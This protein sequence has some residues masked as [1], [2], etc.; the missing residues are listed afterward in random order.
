MRRVIRFQVAAVNTNRGLI[1]RY[2]SYLRPSCA[3][4]NHEKRLLYIIVFPA[5]LLA[6]VISCL[7]YPLNRELLVRFVF[8]WHI[9]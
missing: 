7:S 8:W 4:Q 1:C 9:A 5:R 3:S 2:K 6:L